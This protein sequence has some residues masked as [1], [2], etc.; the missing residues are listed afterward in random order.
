MRQGADAHAHAFQRVEAAGEVVGDD[1]DE[2]RRQAALRDEG[3]L[4]LTRQ[5][6]H[7]PGADDVLGEVEIVHAGRSRGFGDA[8]GEVEGRGAQHGELASERLLH[9]AGGGDVQLFRFDTD[10]E[11]GRGKLGRRAVDERDV[12]VAR[13]AKHFGDG[14]ADL[15]GA[16]D[17]DVLHDQYPVNSR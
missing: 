4:G 8:P 14:R 16:D 3:I 12:I 11:F 1:R 5:L 7:P 17:N 13:G 9:R 15:A 6:L 2:A 10:G